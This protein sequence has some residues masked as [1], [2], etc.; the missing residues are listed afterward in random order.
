MSNVETNLG[1]FCI[2]TIFKTFSYMQLL[3]LDVQAE[4]G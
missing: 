3:N 1:I 4:G 2:V